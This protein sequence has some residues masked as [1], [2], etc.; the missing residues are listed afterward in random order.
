MTCLGGEFTCDPQDGS[1]GP[2]GPVCRGEDVAK[3]S[4]P[5]DPARGTAGG[6][7]Q[8]RGSL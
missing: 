7:T 5:R 8:E 6:V 2:C 1:V 3:L 4:G